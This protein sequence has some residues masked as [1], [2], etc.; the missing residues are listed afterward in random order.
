MS[1]IGQALEEDTT[2]IAESEMEGKDGLGVALFPLVS[3]SGA[4]MSLFWP[5]SS[6][7]HELIS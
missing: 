4:D 7:I 5:S 3:Q 1:G 2:S 6:R